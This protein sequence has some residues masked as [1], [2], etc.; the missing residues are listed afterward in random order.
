MASFYFIRHKPLWLT[1]LWKKT[2]ILAAGQLE[3][4]VLPTQ[5][6]HD[7]Q[8]K[9]FFYLWNNF[10]GIIV[11]KNFDYCYR[12]DKRLWYDEWFL[13]ICDLVWMWGELMTWN[14]W[15]L[16]VWCD[17]ILVSEMCVTL[18]KSVCVKKRL[19]QNNLEAILLFS[20]SATRVRPAL[21]IGWNIHVMKM[22][23]NRY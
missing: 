10:S 16:N 18:R 6:K 5:M 15:H 19:I 17:I 1:P 13:R 20:A 23:G 11:P 9:L 22:D 7:I 21:V 14:L 8:E 4:L 3:K 2:M 12:I